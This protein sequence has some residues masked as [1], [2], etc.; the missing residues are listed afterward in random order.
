MSNYYGG[1]ICSGGVCTLNTL[2]AYDADIK[3]VLAK[4]ICV[5]EKSECVNFLKVLIF[6]L[7][8]L[9]PVIARTQQ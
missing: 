1:I 5:A 3:H 9:I 7:I 2:S 4:P 8:F 6:S